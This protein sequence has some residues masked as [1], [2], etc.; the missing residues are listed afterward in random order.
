M[1][2]VLEAPWP[3]RREHE[4]PEDRA[5][6][7]VR[8]LGRKQ[9]TVHAVVNH[10]EYPDQEPG[11]RDQE[12]N[13]KQRRD[14][15]HQVHRHAQRQIRASGADYVEQ[16]ASNTRLGVSGQR[17]MTANGSIRASLQAPIRTVNDPDAAAPLAGALRETWSPRPGMAHRVP[18][19]R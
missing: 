16:S 17:G 15:D 5:D 9:R 19:A 12:R 6:P 18:S 11:G 7:G 3:K 4:Q 14:A 8:S 1:P 10:D 2:E 13:H